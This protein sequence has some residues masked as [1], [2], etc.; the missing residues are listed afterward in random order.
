[1]NI[2][3]LSSR[4]VTAL[5]DGGYQ[6][7]L[8]VVAVWAALKCWRRSNAA[9]RYA[10]WFATL[11]IVAAL[12]VL[13]FLYAG[14]DGAPERD[15]AAK[16]AA[17]ESEAL[18]ANGSLTPALSQ[19]ER[20]RADAAGESESLNPAHAVSQS[21]ANA[22][23]VSNIAGAV[24]EQSLME[25]ISNTTGV[26]REEASTAQVA[27][28][29]GAGTSSLLSL[30]LARLSALAQRREW[31]LEAPGKVSLIL[32]LAWASLSVVR[33]AG[34]AGQVCLLRGL[35]R[36][37]AAAPAQISAPF[38]ALVKKLGLARQPRL[39][40]SP[41][42]PAPMVAGF[43]HPAVLLPQH[44]MAEA[45]E[46]QLEHVLRHELAHLAR[47]D[48]WANLLQQA[49][50][51]VFFFHPGVIFVSRRMS[52]EREIAC[53]DHA[54]QAI[55]APREYA[56]FLTEFAGRMTGRGIAAAPA[57]WSN[58]SQLK[59]R[60]SMILDGK[61][62]ASPRLAGVRAATMTVG[63]ALLAVL[64]LEVAPRVALAESADTL[65]VEQAEKVEVAE[66]AEGAEPVI[67]AD[68]LK[69]EDVKISTSDGVLLAEV[70]PSGPREKL[71][72]VH[73]DVH[74]DGVAPVQ[75]L[76]P[77]EPRRA[78][79]AQVAVEGMPSPAPS[80]A[81]APSPHPRHERDRDE[82]LERRLD[83]LEKR[84]EELLARDRSPRAPGQP[85]A[86]A[87]IE[88]KRSELHGSDKPEWRGPDKFEWHSSD[89][90]D[91]DHIRD[92]ARRDAEQARREAEQARRDAEHVQHEMQRMQKDMTLNMQRTVKVDGDVKVAYNS[93]RQAL[94]AK[95]EALENARRDL[96][97]Q[98]EKLDHELQEQKQM[99]E[100]RERGQREELREKERALRDK[101]RE[102]RDKDKEKADKEKDKPEKEKNKEKEKHK[103]GDDDN[104][105]N[106]NS[107]NN[108]DKGPGKP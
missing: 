87:Y 5:V 95:K 96:D 21:Q 46:L 71:S 61:R 23:D 28:T 90:A 6:G 11:L 68:T 17:G 48:D 47:G 69:V 35:K 24:S 50:G 31:R 13:H 4:L 83:R 65:K 91:L 34:L 105:S 1:M 94:K 100:D 62:N 27:T 19:G 52:S 86:E 3:M 72:D 8:V 57:A 97:K 85:H 42:I 16:V 103:E 108:A 22:E 30:W 74:V 84:V 45:S 54:L 107:S 89:K 18:V 70:A 59:E 43:A 38:C 92:Q 49:I 98:L 40:T 10:A 14:L 41:E 101:E 33:L 39:L 67:A 32:V 7:A 75:P 104:A 64:A 106:K 60:I 63:A 26:V 82:S 80:A 37:A 81:P 73:V 58:K 99:M 88:G 15:V 79:L 29:A 76:P 44:V 20:G 66:T 12:P 25:E 51:A 2:E 9:T 55:R 93:E 56:L 78:R 102:K 53:D 77:M 36:R